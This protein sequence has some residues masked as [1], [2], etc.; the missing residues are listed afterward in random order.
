MDQGGVYIDFQ[1]YLLGNILF[2]K[3]LN[4]LKC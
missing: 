1:M 2:L 4:I 3:G